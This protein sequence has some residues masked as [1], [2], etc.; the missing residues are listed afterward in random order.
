MESLKDIDLGKI[1][2]MYTYKGRVIPR[3]TSILSKMI[4]EDYLLYWANSLGFKRKGYKQ[5]LGEAA[6]YGARTH[7]GIEEFLQEKEVPNNTPTNPIEAFKRWWNIVNSTNKVKI[8][9]QEVS[10]TCPWFGGTYDLLIEINGAIYLVDF[11]TSNRLSYKYCLQL[12]AYN[13]M[14][15]FNNLP[16]ISGVIVLRLKKDIPDFEELVL[17]FTNPN[18]LDF[19]NMCERTYLSLVHS[20]YHISEVERRYKIIGEED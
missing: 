13:Y 19:F 3:V 1:N 14:V 16:N 7:K 20:Y 8:L 5:T 10:L 12:A 6:D 15:K 9:G 4:H 2:S 17:D 11:K 18:T